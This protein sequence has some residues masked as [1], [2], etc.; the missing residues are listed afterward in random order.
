MYLD[1]H[2]PKTT[3]E[4]LEDYVKLAEDWIE[5]VKSGKSIKT[6]YPFKAEPIFKMAELLQKKTTFI[7]NTLIVNIKDIPYQLN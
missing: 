1:V 4:V 7:K 3:K 5:N 6:C 2:G